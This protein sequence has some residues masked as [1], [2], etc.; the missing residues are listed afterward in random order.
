[1][2]GWAMRWHGSGTDPPPPPDERRPMS[3]GT[4]GEGTRGSGTGGAGRTTATLLGLLAVLAWSTLALFTVWSGAVPPFLL[5]ALCFAVGGVLGL[6]ALLRSGGT[7]LHQPVK[8]WALGVG[9]IFAYHFLYFSAL[10]IAPA[11]EANLINYTW[12]LLIVLFSGLLPGERLG[13]LHFLGAV[14][15][16]LGV[17]LLVMD[18]AN[19]AFDLQY[20]P[21]YAIAVLCALVW[22]SYSV[23][24]RLVAHVP[25]AMVSAFCLVSSVLAF[26]AHLALEDTV[27]PA[28][29]GEWGAVFALGLA[30]VGGAFYVWDIG[31]KHGDIQL[32]GA[33]AYASPLVATILLIVFGIAPAAPDLF[34]AAALIVGGAA[35]AAYASARGRRR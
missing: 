10:R 17:S 20:A 22:S 7:V 26:G 33:A 1:M 24:S 13:A 25:S 19:F 35:T 6:P 27:W 15:G 29:V 8:V 16:L 31:M 5:C 9:G 14:F 30:P 12:P 3:A 28:S 32:L 18:E 4:G 11:A 21:G 34:V 2:T 23:L